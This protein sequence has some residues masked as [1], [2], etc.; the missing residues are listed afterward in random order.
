MRY[1]LF[2]TPPRSRLAEARA[3]EA[4]RIWRA[5]AD[6]LRAADEALEEARREAAEQAAERAALEGTPTAGALA[7]ARAA[8]AAAQEAKRAAEQARARATER[9][10]TERAKAAAAEAKLA[11]IEGKLA[12]IRLADPDLPS[13]LLV[14]RERV[15][16]DP[17]TE[18]VKEQAKFTSTLDIPD[19][20]RLAFV[21]DADV[22]YGLSRVYEARTAELNFDVGIFRDR[23]EAIKWLRQESDS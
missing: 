16:L 19:G 22:T 10:E 13:P 12:D 7:K 6:R 20:S 18:V 17:S 15:D 14:C 4:E 2:P 9:E 5:E 8:E 11:D 1:S 21:V 23:D 3:A